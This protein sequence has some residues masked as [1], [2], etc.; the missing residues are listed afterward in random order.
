[1]AYETLK[2]ELMYNV[3]KSSTNKVISFFNYES[4][5]SLLV[6]ICMYKYII[7]ESDSMVTQYAT[8]VHAIF[9]NYFKVYFQCSG[10]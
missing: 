10:D 8:N 7:S 6:Y 5:V 3:H 2:G 9:S 4:E 1:M